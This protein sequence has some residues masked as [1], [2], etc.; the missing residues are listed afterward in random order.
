ML[1][2]ALLGKHLLRFYPNKRNRVSQAPRAC[3]SS[4][5]QPSHSLLQS[6]HMARPA[7]GQPTRS[8]LHI[9]DAVQPLQ[10]LTAFNGAPHRPGNMNPHSA[11]Q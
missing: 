3:A 2:T 4:C 9:G 11:P 1:L 5:P 10:G 7:G 8:F 6:N